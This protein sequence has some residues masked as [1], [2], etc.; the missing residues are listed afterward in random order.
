MKKYMI[1]V[2]ALAVAATA[3]FAA[4]HGDEIENAIK[5]RKILMGSNGDSAAVAGAMLKGEL[6]YNP[7]VAKAVLKSIQAVSH[8]YGNFFPEGSHSMEGTTALPKIWDN[9]DE[10]AAALAKFQSSTDAAVEAA[11]KE[12]PANID[13]FKAA[14]FPIFDNC[15]SCHE[16]FRVKQ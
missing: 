5:T 9:P 15:Q 11:G 1:A 12:G 10:W 8:A 13:A 2:C 14:I 3:A 6:D 4:G 7:V 16:S